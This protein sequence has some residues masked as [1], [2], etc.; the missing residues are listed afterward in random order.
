MT[1]EQGGNL[2]L[3]ISISEETYNALV[4]PFKKVEGQRLCKSVITDACISIINGIPLSE[5]L[6]QNSWEQHVN[7]LK[8]I[9]NETD[10][11]KH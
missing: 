6:Y 9:Y 1:K 4:K 5:I 3:V 2:V 8:E 10:K 7:F 11:S